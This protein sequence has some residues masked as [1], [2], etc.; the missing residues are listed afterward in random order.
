MNRPLAVR[1]TWVT[2]LVPTRGCAAGSG[3][4][5]GAGAGAATGAT[6]AARTTGA[7]EGAATDAGAVTPALAAGADVD[8]AAALPAGAR[9]GLP[10]AAS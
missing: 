2:E 5:A 10:K 8:G 9:E 7:G 1:E 6:G 3:V 4:A